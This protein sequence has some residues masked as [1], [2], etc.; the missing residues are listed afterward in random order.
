MRAIDTTH[1]PANTR[2]MRRRRRRKTLAARVL[3]W[4]SRVTRLEPR[5]RNCPAPPPMSFA[6]RAAALRARTACVTRRLGWRDLQP[7]T[8]LRAVEKGLCLQNGDTLQT[9]AYIRVV[10]VR[11]EP[12]LRL[13]WDRIYGLDE[14]RLEGLS[15]HPILCE[16]SAYVQ[17]FCRL[18][19]C[20]VTTFITRIRFDYVS[21][22][23]ADLTER[24]E[25][26]IQEAEETF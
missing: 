5:A 3:E 19:G 16:P 12:L 18:Y 9:L 4:F 8:V 13:E 24:W 17:F 11:I 1:L 20:D 21:Q 10:D 2:Q 26:V 22:L 23:D 14:C 7:G 6:L 15:D 25:D